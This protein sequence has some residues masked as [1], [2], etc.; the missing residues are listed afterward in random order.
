VE[1]V[2]RG[3]HHSQE[4]PVEEQDMEHHWLVVVELQD[5][6]FQDLQVDHHLVV[7]ELAAEALG[8]LV[9]EWVTDLVA[10]EYPTLLV[11]LH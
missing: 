5:K 1:E 8:V 11:V 9:E 6:D 10:Q 3:G 7:K 2:N 4:V